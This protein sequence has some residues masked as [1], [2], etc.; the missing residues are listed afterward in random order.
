MKNFKFSSKEMDNDQPKSVHKSG[1]GGY[2]PKHRGTDPQN[3]NGEKGAGEE[4]A[5]FN[6]YSH[7][8]F[9]SKG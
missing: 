7:N 5:Q 8:K 6:H 4:T 9:A 2:D 3:Q 1:N